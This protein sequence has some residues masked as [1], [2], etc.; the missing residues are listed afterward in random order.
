MGGTIPT[1]ATRLFIA[2]ET[3]V[4][5]ANMAL[6]LSSQSSHHRRELAAIQHLHN[7]SIQ[8]LREE[9]LASRQ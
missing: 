3:H 5:E 9:F 2:T 7:Q 6:R 1:D 8:A 4:H